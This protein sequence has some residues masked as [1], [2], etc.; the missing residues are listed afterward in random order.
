MLRG[1]LFF[2]LRLKVYPNEE[3]Y[4]TLKVLCP[5][6]V[7]ILFGINSA[8]GDS[9]KIEIEAQK[10]TTKFMKTFVAA[11]QAFIDG[12]VLI[13]DEDYL[14]SVGFD[15]SFVCC[16]EKLFDTLCNLSYGWKKIKTRGKTN[17]A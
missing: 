2:L 8:L 12:L 14:D 9:W 1:T 10:T 3:R 17:F 16:P 6:L 7:R 15:F 5:K 11:L 4:L 13:S